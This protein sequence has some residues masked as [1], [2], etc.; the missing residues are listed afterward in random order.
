MTAAEK[1]CLVEADHPLVIEAQELAAANDMA[2]V[3]IVVWGSSE[4]LS[5]FCYPRPASDRYG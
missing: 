3:V 5:A 4:E 1:M 2:G